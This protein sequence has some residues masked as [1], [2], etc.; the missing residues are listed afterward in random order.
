MRASLALAGLLCLASA[1][2]RAQPDAREPE[3]QGRARAR[4][5][6]P[7]YDGLAPPDRRAEDAALLVPRLVLLPLHV[8]LE[9][10]VRRPLAWVATRVDP[11]WLDAIRSALTWDEGRALVIPTVFWD[12]G[13]RPSVGA[14]LR[15]TDL[16]AEGHELRAG[17]ATWGLDWLHAHLRSASRL[18]RQTRIE[19]NVSGSRRQD[20]VFAGIGYDSL[21]EN[22]SRFGWSEVV[23]ELAVAVEL[24]HARLRASSGVSVVDLDETDFRTD[25][26]PS[27]AEAVEAGL[28]PRP[29]GFPGRYAVVRQRLEGSLDSRAGRDD[30]LPDGLQVRLFVEPSIDPASAASWIRWGAGAIAAIDLGGSRWLGTRALVEFADPLEESTLPFV[31]LIDLGERWLPFGAYLR[32]RL[33]GRS[34]IATSLEYRYAIFPWVDAHLFVALGNAFDAH[35]GDLR[36]ERL[37]FAFGI[38]L[39]A[40]DLLDGVTVLVAFGSETFEQ[41]AALS[42]IRLALGV[43]TGP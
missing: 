5:P 16:F 36:L 21:H 13:F 32:G 39:R 40:T 12:L 22:I 31:E 9:Y 23:G 19:L 34:A 42:S 20:G 18:G 10:L 38:G 28:Y 15:W 29:P 33:R 27:L 25:G 2:A 3:P 35:L 24:P 14:R 30:A 8:V 4:R 26:D 7:D 37:R 17:F 43:D 1:T 11:A 6:V 41:G